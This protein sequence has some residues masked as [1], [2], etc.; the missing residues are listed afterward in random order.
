MV[1]V[2]SRKQGKV[3]RGA[4]WWDY[5]L[6]AIAKVSG[7]TT[8]W[9]YHFEVKG[10]LSDGTIRWDYLLEVKQRYHVELSG[11]STTW[12]QLQRYQAGL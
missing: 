2:S 6:E 10:W 7:G 8:K 5:H 11:R 9:T 3:S 12:S 1:K 4:I